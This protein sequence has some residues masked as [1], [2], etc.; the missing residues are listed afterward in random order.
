[1]TTITKHLLL[2]LF[3]ALPFTGIAQK[4]VLQKEQLLQDIKILS[5]DSLEG[6]LSGT[7]GNKL[8]QEYIQKRFKQIGLQSYGDSYKQHFKLESKRVVV[9]QASN[10]VGYILGK[11]EGFIVVTA[12][13]DHVGVREGEVYNGAD[14]NASGVGGLLAAASYFKKHKPKHTILF[15]ALDG[16]ELGLQGANAFLEN[17]PVPKERILLN[18]NMDMLSLNNKGELYASGTYHY[19]FLRPYL[20][21]VAPRP[22]AKLVL[23]HDLPEQG[24]DDWTGQSDHYQF[25]KRQI[26]FVYFGVEDHPHYHKPTDEYQN[27]NASFYPDAA[28]LVIDFVQLADQNLEHSRQKKQ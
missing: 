15:V 21:Q 4:T 22:Q 3:F 7:P 14:D 8:A 10:L 16:E 28:S 5:A 20:E 9:E 19:P 12:H 2:G 17:T 24:H 27:I 18:V 26:P 6:R 11:K 23:G 13:Y 25:H 1:M